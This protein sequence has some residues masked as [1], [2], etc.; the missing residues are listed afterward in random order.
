MYSDLLHKKGYIE[1]LGQKKFL[2]WLKGAIMHDMTAPIDPGDNDIAT[3]LKCS[4]PFFSYK[5]RIKVRKAIASEIINWQDGPADLPELE[6][7][8]LYELIWLCA[9]IE[10]KEAF[11]K[12]LDWLESESYKMDIDKREVLKRQLI[13]CGSQKFLTEDI[14]ACCLRTLGPCPS[15]RLI[16]VCLRDISDPRYFLLCY[17]ILR[18]YDLIYTNKYFPDFVRYCLGE[19]QSLI[20]FKNGIAYFNEL[21]KT[22]LR[23]HLPEIYHLLSLEEKNFLSSALKYAEFR[24]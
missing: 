1:K 18:E 10:A 5:N 17:R 6:L 16:G 14:H 24:T 8:Y 15:G 22:K 9:N 12:L 11:E 13:C 7:Y 2:Q 3:W 4:F 19:E 21:C 23:E 20:I